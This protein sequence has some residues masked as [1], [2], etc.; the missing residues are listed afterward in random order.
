MSR[1][2]KRE[3]FAPNGVKSESTIAFI[4]PFCGALPLRPT[5][6]LS[7]RPYFGDSVIKQ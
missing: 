7:P 4:G 6:G 5:R 1:L 2:I 3:Q